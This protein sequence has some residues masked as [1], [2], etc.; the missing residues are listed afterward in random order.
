VNA[1]WPEFYYNGPSING[2][3]HEFSVSVLSQVNI[4]IVLID[5]CWPSGLEEPY[6][7][8]VPVV[9][10]DESG[11]GGGGDPGEDCCPSGY[12][13]CGL[14]CYDDWDCWGFCNATYWVDRGYPPPPLGE[15]QW[16]WCDDWTPV[17][18]DLDG[19]GFLMTP[20]A[21]GVDLDLSG[22]GKASK[23]AWTAAGANDGWLAIDVNG[24][25]LIDGGAELFGNTSPQPNVPGRNGFKALAKY[26]QPVDGGNGDGLIDQ[27]DTVYSRLLVWVDKN[28]NGISEPA[29]LHTLAQLGITSIS[30]SCKD[31]KWVDAH[32]NQFRYRA[33]VDPNKQGTTIAHWAYDV[34][35]RVAK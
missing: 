20:A 1:C 8:S 28:H 30:L 29:E 18:I 2:S 32:G 19:D 4:P 16:G 35:L 7:E 14:P 21:E 17:L 15:Y 33:K 22:N 6:S 27:S 25:G 13:D 24:N 3:S 23:V 26:D 9:M 12:G 34:V 11:G 10:C 31:S 5:A